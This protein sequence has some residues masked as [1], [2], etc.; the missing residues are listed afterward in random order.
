MTAD[1]RP[2]RLR[3]AYRKGG[4]LRY[5]GHLDLMRTWE[6]ALR[7]AGLPLAYTQGFS[8]HAR[9]A[10]GAPLAV[11]FEGERELLDVWLSPS[12]PPLE[13]ARRLGEALPDGLA[14]LAVEE[15][16]RALPSLQ[17]DIT[18]ATYE[19]AFEAGDADAADLRWRA[20]GLLAAHSLEWEEQ[21]GDRSRR[22]DLRATVRAVEV[23]EEGGRVVLALDL[24]AREGLTGR[25]LAVLEA[26]GVRAVP[27]V[28]RRTGL[29]LGEPPP[30]PPPAEPQADDTGEA[31]P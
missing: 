10:L 20:E 1:E 15:I 3:V 14:V 13:V 27:A 18:S 2:Q 21:R 5:V 29:R 4:A 11:G 26:M 17:S 23:R 16:D 30:A 25:P 7:R 6:R 9:L 12:A 31:L 28:R 8:P 24:E 19:L 22:Y